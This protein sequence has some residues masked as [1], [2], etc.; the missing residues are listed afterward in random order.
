MFKTFSPTTMGVLLALIS[1]ALY[2][3][4]DALVKGLGNDLSVFEIGLFTTLFSLL[5]AIFGKPADEKLGDAFK[6][7]RPLITTLIAVCRTASV[8]FITYSF[9]TIPLAEAYSLVFLVPVMTIMLSVV[10]LREKVGLD[11]WVLAAISFIGVVIVVRPGFKELELGHLTAL[12]CAICAAVSVIATRYT[13]NVERKLSL[14][15][16]PA[17]FTLTANGIGLFIVGGSFPSLP[18]LAG[19]AACGIIGGIAYL[20]Q[21]TALAKAP[22]SHIAPMQYSQIVWALLFGALFFNEAPDLIG[23]I[24]LAIVVVSGVGNLLIDHARAYLVNR[25][26]TPPVKDTGAGR[27]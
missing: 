8:M 15:A 23:V 25:W 27:A 1:Y 26:G 2:S 22:A 21:L 6:L 20:M 14:F 11:R 5:P 19:L 9:V 3:T 18:L 7:R 10:V 17:L 4:G 13:A 12:L 16:V 24:G